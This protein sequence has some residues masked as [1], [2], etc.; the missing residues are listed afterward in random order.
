MSNYV[1][2]SERYATMT[3]NRCGRSG[4]KLPA[5]SLGLWQ[6]MNRLVDKGNT[7]IV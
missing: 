6:M 3:Y 1:A 4:L 5:I 2:S 7:V